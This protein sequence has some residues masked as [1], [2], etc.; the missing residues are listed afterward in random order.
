MLLLGILLIFGII[1]IS[2]NF[3]SNNIFLGS[4]IKLSGNSI[5]DNSLF[6][7]TNQNSQNINSD[8]FDF[9]AQGIAI[10]LIYIGIKLLLTYWQIEIADWI[11]FVVILV[12]IF[13]SMI[14][15]ALF[16]KKAIPHDDNS[17][18]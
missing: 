6:E 16:D 3:S 9:L 10:A 13:G 17:T 14:V 7:K 8:K 18:D 5:F 4:T 11:S 1:I 12:C 15:S 2:V